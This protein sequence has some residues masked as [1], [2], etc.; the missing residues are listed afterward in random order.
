M[1]GVDTMEYRYETVKT[2]EKI[3]LRIFAHEE[4]NGNRPIN[5]HWH[6]NIE[7]IYCL[8]GCIHCAIHAEKHDLYKGQLLLINSND[9]HSLYSDPS[10]KAIILQL[11]MQY[12]LSYYQEHKHIRLLLTP[13]VQTEEVEKIK[14]CMEE[15]LMLKKARKLGYDLKIHSLLYEIEYLLLSNFSTQQEDASCIIKT[16]KYLDRLSDITNYLQSHFRDDIRLEDVA[17]RFSLAPPYLSRFFKKY[18]NISFSDYLT[19]I[20]LTQAYRDLMN[21]D[22]S[23]MKIALDNGFRNPRSFAEAFRNIYG[24]TPSKFRSL[25]IQ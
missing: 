2:D 22:N 13:D 25:H 24:I 10:A 8:D 15:M 23:I 21:T 5:K 4:V 7:L 3:P 18:A 17:E 6:E 11:P 19:G 1:M 14:T 16:Q 20:R 12:F 9:I